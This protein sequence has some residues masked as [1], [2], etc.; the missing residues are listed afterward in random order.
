MTFTNTA[1]E[2]SGADR[3]IALAGYGLL[4]ASVFTFGA[5]GIAAAILAYASRGQVSP[6]VRRHLDAQI[7]MFWIAF[8]LFLVSTTTLGAAVLAE[9]NDLAHPPAGL[10]QGG[11][12]DVMGH[13]IDLRG[14]QVTPVVLVLAGTSLLTGLIGAL[15][16]LIGPT[17]GFIRLAIVGPRGVTAQPS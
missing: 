15:L 7:T 9:I 5:T 14:L 12:I 6:G 13:R 4:F 3:G 10:P 11:H 2:K 17:F 8:V 1:L 16:T